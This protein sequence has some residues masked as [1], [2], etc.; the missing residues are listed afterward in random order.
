MI[1]CSFIIVSWNAKEYL[2]NCVRSIYAESGSVTA[3]V[4]V[5]DN[6]SVDGSAD[7]VAEAFPDV[8]VIRND[9]NAGF[10]RA[11]NQGIEEASGRHLFLV[12]SDV[13]ILPGTIER[14]VAF[15]DANPAAAMVG[16]RVLN[17]DRSVQPSVMRLPTVRAA[18]C[19]ALAVDSLLGR[20]AVPDGGDAAGEGH[21][22]EALSGCFWVL[23]REAV[24]AV[25][26]LDDRFFMYGEDLDWCRR[27][28]QGGWRVVYYPGAEA[29]H[30]G[31]ASS[32]NAP[33]RFVI[34]LNRAM[35]QYWRKHH[36]VVKLGLVWALMLV[37]QVLR[38]AGGAA[39]WAVSPGKRGA[40]AFTIHRS[41]ALIWW[42][43]A[44]SYRNR[45]EVA[46]C[47]ALVTSS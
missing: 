35:L 32:A 26:L 29:I 37:G 16:P 4:I 22:V 5:V 18:L 30:F 1:D 42:L 17:A 25:G 15:M 28:A 33:I 24:A 14:L 47:R 43:L 3:E 27:F 7:A 6:A 21:D 46:P 39:V 2:L 36:G 23:R 34:E 40:A 10:A 9:G 8:R 19:R 44:R 38:L 31:G 12:N 11:N 45:P 41:R 13:L 20:T